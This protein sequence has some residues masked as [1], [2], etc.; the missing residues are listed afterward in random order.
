MTW[1]VK[2]YDIN[3][4]KI[5]D[6]N[7]LKYLEPEI[8]KFKKIAVLDKNIFEDLLRRRLMYQFWSRAEY[9]LVLVRGNGLQLM[10]LFSRDKFDVI[11][12]DVSED[13]FWLSFASWPKVRWH[14]DSAKLDVWQQVELQWENFLNYCWTFRHKYERLHREA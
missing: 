1:L 2:L 10:P 6:F 7:I 8:K 4:R 13:P 3:A 11:S 14:G 9:E 12:L 5:I